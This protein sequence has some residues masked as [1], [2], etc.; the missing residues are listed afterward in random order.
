M[1]TP[2]VLKAKRP[3]NQD[4]LPRGGFGNLIALPLQKAARAKNANSTQN[5]INTGTFL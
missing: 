3:E 5:N 2:D 4:T 1:F